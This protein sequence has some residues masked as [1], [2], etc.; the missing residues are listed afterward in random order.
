MPSVTPDEKLLAPASKSRDIPLNATLISP[1]LV[2]T[3]EAA[4][5]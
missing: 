2:A 3:N 1:V 5:F 4:P